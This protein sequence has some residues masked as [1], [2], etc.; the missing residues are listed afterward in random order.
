MSNRIRKCS[1]CKKY[2]LKDICCNEKT[3]NPSPAKYSPED[4]YAKYRRGAKSEE[5]EKQEASKQGD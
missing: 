5:L 2:T 4:K 1:I 3:L